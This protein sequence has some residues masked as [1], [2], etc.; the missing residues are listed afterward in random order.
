MENLSI[1]EVIF[2]WKEEKKKYVKASTYATYMVLIEKHILPTFGDKFSFQELDIQSFV[3]HKLQNHMSKK[4]LKDILM[5]LKMIMKYGVKHGYFQYQE[6]DIHFPTDREKKELEVF[7]IE[8]QKKILNYIKTHFNFENLGILICLNTGM[9]IGEICALTWNDI[10]IQNETIH[11]HK[12]LQRIY[13]FEKTKKQ[14]KLIL[15]TPKTKN[16]IRNIPILPELL[17]LL[18]SIKKVVNNEYFILSN[19]STPLEPRAY[20]NYYKNLLNKIGV[21]FIKFHALRHSFATRCVE[22]KCD[23]KTISVILG[24]SSINTTMNLYV[25]PNLEQKRRCLKQM[26]RMLSK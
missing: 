19:G 13:I 12:T 26:A 18:R 8:Q 15:D 9:R 2:L 11:I 17:S 14:T 22:S 20:R 21:P 23:Y 1:Q 16:S 4:T 3:F 10:D 6:F 5:I 7:S 24:H 25:H